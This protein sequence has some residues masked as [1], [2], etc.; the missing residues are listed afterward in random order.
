MRK[1]EMAC[2]RLRSGWGSVS[3]WNGCDPWWPRK[4]FRRSNSHFLSVSPAHLPLELQEMLNGEKG[5]DC[6]CFN[7]CSLSFT[8]SVPSVIFLIQCYLPQKMVMITVATPWDG[9][10]T[11]RKLIFIYCCDKYLLSAC[12]VADLHQALVVQSWKN[13]QSL[14][15]WNVQPGGKEWT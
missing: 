13:R 2:E 11:D 6:R 1:Q 12:C 8:G 3:W 9:S 14:F 5:T 4:A 7:P 10:E 15:W